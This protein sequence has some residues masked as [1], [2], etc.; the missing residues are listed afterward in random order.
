VAEQSY[1][2]AYAHFLMARSKSKSASSVRSVART[3]HFCLLIAVI[4]GYYLFL[5]SNGTFQ[6]FAPE[7][8]DKAF[9]NMLVHL[10]HGEFTV[11]PAAID[12]EAFTRN[13]NTYS[14]FGV[15]PAL[16]RLVAL[17]FTDVA[18][19]ELARVSCLTADVIFI[20][21][22]LRM[23]VIVHRQLAAASRR[24]GF[25]AVMM[26][27]TVLS[28]PQ[29][30][31]LGSAS[32]Y[33]EP[34]L[35]SAAMAA[36][37]SLIIVRAAFGARSLGSRD[38]ILLAALAGLSIITR[39]TIGVALYLG[40]ILLVG[41]T[42]WCRSTSTDHGRERSVE[43]A[44]LLST[45]APS[46]AVLGLGAV[47]IGII[48]FQRWGN[49]LTF[50]DFRHYNW[51][52]RHPN[53]VHA[54]YNHGEFDVGRLWVGAL[55]YAT[56]LPYLL[57]N[58]PP[59]D[60]FLSA[61]VAI[62]EA[63]PLTPFLT[64][65]LTIFLAGVGLYRLWHK[66]GLP[67]NSVAV[68]RLTLIGHASAVLFIFAAMAFTLRYRFDLAPFMTLSALIGYRSISVTVAEARDIWRKRIW[69]TAVGLCALGI[70]SSH[71]VLLIHKVWSIAVPMNVRL[72]L[73]PFAPFAHTAFEP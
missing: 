16:L 17:P 18:Q 10:L 23:L 38:L 12:F 11:D 47:A 40:T 60:E 27:A 69:I 50:A 32:I 73:L 44:S 9:G 43:Q 24:S 34:I 15:F 52:Y 49:P 72:A 19:A 2:T 28:G 66:P 8:L 62:I 45:V 35:W 30:Y 54:F 3:W 42:M 41:W 48:N 29:I 21:L 33:H 22:Q 14:Y 46:V 7:M 39:P 31:I 51:L 37:F 56:G 26:T 68:L 61:R 70:L 59:F 5:L 13:G 64:N 6:L 25:L 63:P 4:A 57:K 71:Y 58:I 53:F 1:S 65:P 36:G 67:T 55:Y 20:A